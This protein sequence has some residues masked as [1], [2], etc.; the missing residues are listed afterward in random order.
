MDSRQFAEWQAY[1]A[2]EPWDMRQLFGI[3]CETIDRKI[4][5]LACVLTHTKYSD[6]YTASAAEYMPGHVPGKRR[7]KKRQQS[8]EDMAKALGWRSSQN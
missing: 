3:L 4:T 5:E 7:R 1:E 6:E 8:P 2:C